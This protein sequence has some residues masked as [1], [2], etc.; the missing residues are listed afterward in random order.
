MYPEQAAPDSHPS[1][2]HPG[3]TPQ[4]PHQQPSDTPAV[5]PDSEVSSGPNPSDTPGQHPDPDSRPPA[6]TDSP[7][8]P[9]DHGD[10]S[11]HQTHDG[12]EPT[13]PDGD[14]PNPNGHDNHDPET[15]PT[16]HDSLQEHPTPE[17]RASADQG[18]GDTARENGADN[19]RTGGEKTCSEDPVDIATGEFLLPETDVNLPGV[20]ALTL[21]RTHR[22]N[23]RYG[24]WFGPS[25]ATTLDMRLVVEHEGVTFL[26]EDGIMLAYP[27]TEVGAA[28]EPVTGGQAWT[29]TRTEVGGY[30]IW[31]QQ[32][33]ILWH[34]APEPTLDGIDSRLGNYAISAI[35]DRHRNRIRF[36]YDT[37]GAPVEVS[38]SVGYRVRIDTA[39]GRVTGLS[40][41]DKDYDGAEKRIRIREFGYEAG[42]LSTVANAVGATTGYTYD[43]E[44]RLRS[45]TDSNG[46]QMVNTYDESGR[47]IFQRGTAGILDTDFDYLEFPDG[48]GR[49]T[50]V[51]NSLGATTSHGFDRDFRLRDLVD[52]VGGRTHID[53]NADRKPLKVIAPD[54]AVT[55]YRYTGEGDIAEIVRPDGHTVQI[56]YMWRNRPTRVADADGT[57]REQE[58]NK[59]GNLAASVDSAGART[60]YAYHSNGAIAELIDADNT[61]TRIEVDA[62]GLP[63]QVVAQTGATTRIERDSCGRPVRV[64]DPMDARTGYEWAPDGKLLRRVDPDGYAESWTYDGEGNPLTHTDRA[65]NLTR[66]VYGAFDLLRSRT[67]PDGST[68]HYTWDSQRRLT[69]VTNPLGQTWAYGYDPAGRL[70]T[71]TDYTG[72]TTRYTHDAA[73]R[74]T[75]IT[76]AT[77]ITRHHTRDLLGRLT[78]VT[79]DTG[80]WIRYTHDVAGRVLTAIAGTNEDLTHTL[81]FTYTAT[82]KLASQQLDDQPTMRHEH[83]QYS[84]R[85]RRTTPT[86]ATT[87]WD[88]DGTGRVRGLTADGHKLAFRYDSI[89]RLE[90]WRVGEIA[91][92]RTLSEISRVTGQH[93]I[94]HP[95]TS[96][97]LDTGPR[98]SPRTLRHDEY[99]YRPDGYLINHTLT[100]PDTNSVGSDYILD[101]VGRVTSITRNST[102]AE[103]YTYDSL[104]NI[105]SAL[106]SGLP[107]NTSTTATV[108][109]PHD[110]YTPQP[111]SEADSRREYRNNLLIR[112]GRTRYHYD[113]AGRLIRK[114]I[115]R[116][117]RKAD[118]W[119]YRYNSFDQLT[120]VWTPDWPVPNE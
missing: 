82:G 58:W 78:A 51:T 17:E 22:S 43:D 15:R 37:D 120:D 57:V 38:H 64:T 62:A 49:L 12:T 18:A 110:S 21:R 94:A 101:P 77:G 48:T 80:E 97:S 118:I 9:T 56:D 2:E 32:R 65:G 98:S 16:H 13:H 31:D 27:H 71:Q 72:A 116:L 54:G 75:T 39:A 89:G 88:Y 55:C 68:T 3:D 8:T 60:E 109:D 50:T 47:V 92:D 86:G 67:D 23:Y 53:Y 73:G 25:W 63:V 99:T 105:T 104:S 40:V 41:L 111:E 35:T 112:D 96:L 11:S 74:A 36:H 84:R 83:D 14:G 103:Q 7:D 30:R 28:T 66:F 117:S 6:R 42:Q 61:S 113:G 26:G 100:R 44:H 5:R 10:G 87:G 90:S 70:I 29:L 102:I 93:V 33:E 85:I 19:D 59:N 45:W 34:F 20:L 108:A 79:T 106:Q 76:P 91:I 115:A 52:P 69:R 81:E 1:G 4:T 119:H 46:N 95:A 107:D 114:T 24:R